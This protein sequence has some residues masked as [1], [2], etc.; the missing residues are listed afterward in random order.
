M[1]IISRTVKDDFEAVTIANIIAKSGGDVF[2]VVCSE[3]GW[4][5]WATIHSDNI[6]LIDRTFGEWLD[7]LGGVYV[8]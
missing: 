6:N 1:Q 4:S 2:S 7:T 5:V 8:S 3:H